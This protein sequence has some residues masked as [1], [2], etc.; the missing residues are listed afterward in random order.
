M[1]SGDQQAS[2]TGLAAVEGFAI[3]ERETVR[4]FV[5]TFE[6]T[7]YAAPSPRTRLAKPLAEATVALIATPGAYER[8]QPPFDEGASAGDPSHRVVAA[9]VA[10]ADICFCHPGI[11][12]GPA[13]A[14][15]DCV[16]PVRLLRRYAEEG[17]IGAVAPHAIALMGYITQID[18]LV[19][20]TAPA[21]VETLVRDEVD[22]ALLVP[23]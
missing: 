12:T 18:Q 10:E 23:A 17:R 11:D 14:D 21:V 9:D 16:F 6:W 19:E 13:E 7:R 15:A 2:G 5:P 20:G 1:A 4:R 22:L 3:I 8:D